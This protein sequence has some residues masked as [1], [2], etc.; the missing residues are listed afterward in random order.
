LRPALLVQLKLC[1]CGAL[2]CPRFVD[3]PAQFARI[4]HESSGGHITPLRDQRISSQE[5]QGNPAI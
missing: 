1:L 2:L 5:P 4:P 3:A